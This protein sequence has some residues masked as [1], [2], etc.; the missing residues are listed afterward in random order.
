MRTFTNITEE[1]LRL[2]WE[3]DGEERELVTTPSHQFLATHGGF[4][5][6]ES[7]VSGGKGRVV[8]ADGSEAE[9]TSERI[10]YSAATADMFEQAEGYVYPENGNL[11]LKPVF[12][13]GWKTYNFEVEDFHTYVAGGVR[14]HNDSWN[15]GAGFEF[16]KEDYGTGNAYAITDLEGIVPVNGYAV[17]AYRLSQS[18]SY[19]STPQGRAESVAFG[20]AAEGASNRQVNA[21]SWSEYKAK[22]TEGLSDKAAAAWTTAH[23]S[24]KEFSRFEASIKHGRDQGRE[25][26]KQINDQNDRNS[27]RDSEGSRADTS[28]SSNPA[29]RGIGR[30]D[31][32]NDGEVSAREF[33]RAENEGQFETDNKAKNNNSDGNSGGNGGS[34]G[35]PVLLDLDGDGLD[36]TALDRST[37]FL[38]TGGD[39]FL[40]RTAW[41]DAGDG[42]LFYDPDGRDGIT[43]KRQFV[44]TEWDPTATSDLEALASVFDSNSDGVL[45]AGDAEFGK[46]KV[47]V[48]LADGSTVA[49][50]L[51][52]L[53]ITAID[54][55]ADAT[56]IELADGSVITGKTTF[57]RSDGTTGTV[58]DML[59]ASEAQGHRVEQ[60]ENVDGTGT[61]TLVS[62]AYAADGS[63]AYEIQSATSADGSSITNRYDDDGDGVTDRIQ[64]IVTVQNADNSET[65]TEETL[66]G[67]DAAT[68]VL[69]SRTVTTV[70]A[71]GLTETIERDTMGGGW[72]NQREV[73]TEQADGSLT[74]VIS[75]LAENGTMIKSRSETV[76]S[77]GSVRVDGIDADGD[78]HADT[79]ETHGIAVHA[80]DSRTE[81]VAVTNQD[82]SLRS[83][84]T[85]EVG[86]DGRSKVITRDLDGNGQTDQQEILDITVAPSG[87][88]T[89]RLDIRN[90]DGSLKSSSV[91]VTSDD[92]L[93]KT[94]ELDQDG[95]GDIDLKTVDTTTVNA[96]GSREQVIT[97]WNGDGSVRAMRKETLGSDKVSF[98]TFVDLNQ[99]GSFDAGERVSFVSVDDTT[100]ARTAT[101]WTRN[102]DGSASA[103][104]TSVTSADGLSSS[105]ESDL[106]GDGDIDLQV[107][108]VTVL[109][110]DG[111]SKRTVTTK[112]QDNS[113]RT[114]VE[115]ETSVDGLTRTVREDVDGKSDGAFEKISVT[116]L[117]LEADGGSKQTAT[118]YAGDGTTVLSKTVTTESADRRI[119]TVRQDRDGDGA[120]DVVSERVE[121]ED[122]SRTLTETTYAN[123]GTVLGQSVSTTSANGL[124]TTTQTDLDGDGNAD[125]V[126][127]ST[128][129]LNADGSQTTVQ[130]T[131]NGDG[132][133]RS[134]STVT[135]SDDGL[136]T[137]TRT[138]ADG[139]GTFERVIHDETVLDADGGTTRTVETRSQSGA[140]INR[141]Q[142]EVSDDGLVREIRTDRDGNGSYDL[143]ETSSTVLEADGDT[144]TTTE[145]RE[146][147]VLRSSTTQTV[148]DN[149]RSNVAETDVN[150]DGKTDT[151]ITQSVADSGLATD[152]VQHK[153]ADGSVQ[154]QVRTVTSANGLSATS[155]QDAD[156]NGAYETRTETVRTLNVDGS[157]TTTTSVKAQ[158]GALQ[159]KSQ[160]TVSDNGLT[161]TRTQDFDGDDNVDET[162]VRETAIASDGS[163]TTTETVTARNNDT[164][165]RS[166]ETTSGDGRSV[167][168]SVDA[169][170]DG[171]NDRVTT[172]TLADDGVTTTVAEAFS[173]SGDP[174][175]RTTT[176]ASGNGLERT[177]SFD[178]DGN[179]VAER[180]MQDTTEIASDGTTTRRV[181]H[182][183]G[184]GRLIAREEMTSSDDGLIV[185]TAL[186]LDGQGGNDFVTTKT[187]SFGHDGSSE[188]SW[189]TRGPGGQKGSAVVTTSANGLE[190]DTLIDMDGDGSIDRETAL[191]LGATGGSTETMDFN[192]VRSTV[193]SVSANGRSQTTTIDRKDGQGTDL[194]IQTSVDLSGDKTTTWTD[195]TDGGA[196]EAVIRREA[197]ANG[198]SDLY[199][200]DI[201]GNG[202]DDITRKTVVDY[203]A[204]GNEIR[205]FE[206]LEGSAGVLAFKSTTITSA[207]GLTSTTQTDSD[208]DGE[209]DT[210][211]E[212][213]T[214]FN[215]DGSSTTTSRDWHD[216]GTL[217]S[218]YAETVSADGRTIVESFDFD[219]NS[220]TDKTVV[221]EVAADGSR[222]VT[223]T[224]FGA[225]GVQKRIVTKT[226]SDGLTTTVLRDG[227]SEVLS[228]SAVGNGSYDWDNGVRA[229]SSKAH[230]F[231]THKI[232]GQGLETWEMTSTQ[233]GVATTHSERFDM[234][235][236]DRLLAEAA[237]LYDAVLDRAMDNS[238]IEVLV[239]YASNSQLNLTALANA[240]LSSGEYA[241]RYGSLSDTGFI[242]R[243]YQ[244]TFGREPTLAELGEH[245]AELTSGTSRAAL[246]AGLSESAE[247][248]VVGN[249]HGKTNNYD[250]F[251]LP[252]VKE[253]DLIVSFG[254]E[255]FDLNTSDD[256]AL[257]GTNASQTLNIGSH[258]AV[259]GLGGNDS[260]NGGNGS[261]I[262]VGGTGNDGL[263]GGAG[264]DVYIVNRG[265]GDDVI[266]DTGSGANGDRL[267]FGEGIDIEDL[268]MIRSGDHLRIE[269][270]AESAAEAAAAA[271]KGLAPLTGS[272]TIR[273][274]FSDNNLRVERLAFDNGESY[275]IGHIS[276]F[277]SEPGVNYNMWRRRSDS[278]DT[279]TA[280]PGHDIILGAGGNDTL[281]GADGNDVLLG[282]DGDDRL[283]GG[284]GNDILDAGE[285]SGSSWQY[286]YGQ[287]GD[288]TYIFGAKNGKVYIDHTETSNTGT[289]T[290][291][292]DE[293]TLNDFSFSTYDF[294]HGGTVQTP[295][296]IGLQFN[297]SGQN[298][299]ALR[300][301][302]MGDHIERYEFADGTVLSRVAF[303]SHD[304]MHFE[305]TDGDD[306]IVG[307]DK[308][309]QIYGGHGDDIIDVGGAA[310]FWQHARGQSGDDTYLIGSNAGRV[311][312][313][314]SSESS[315]NDTIRFKDLTLAD[316]NVI[317]EA[318]EGQGQIL[319]LLW[320][321]NG[322][323]GEL[324]LADEGDHI[325]RFEFA[326]GVT[327]SKIAL[328]SHDRIHVEGTGGDDLIIGTDKDDQI[329]G[330]HGNDIIDVGGAA[331]FWQHARGQSGDDTYLIGSNAG[332]VWIMRSSESS[333]NDTVRFKDLTLADLNVIV[334]AYEG[335]GQILRLLWN[336]N[337]QSGE[338]RL[339]DEGD[340]IERFE[341]AD[342]MTLSKIA[343]SSHD[344]LHL[345]GT[346][347]DDLIIGSDK[348]DQIYGG[349]GDDTI[350]VGGA[351]SF[352]QHAR[353][354]S[355]DDTY[356]IGSDAG[357]IWI[358][359]SSESSGN[360]TVRFKDLTL[361][362]LN[363]IVEAYEGQGQ[364]LRLLWN[365]NGQSGE[366]RLADEGD[367]IERFE[368]ADGAT[369]SKIALSSH[370]R[371]HLEGTNGDDLIIGSDKDDQIYG[372]AGN[373]TI[374]V[375]AGAGHWQHARGQSGD[376]TYLIG[377]EAGNV[378]IMRSS[379]SSGYD[380]VRFKDLALADLNV[381]VEAYEGQG[382]ILRLLWNKD[383]KSGQ[384]RL[385]DEGDHIERFE[386]ADGT[387]LA[388]V[389]LRSDGRLGLTGDSAANL[390][391]GTD[392]DEYLQGRAGD[393]ILNGGA[394]SDVIR[395]GFG[396]DT[397]FGGA[398]DDTIYFENGDNFWTN[399]IAR[400]V[401]GEGRDKLI[402]EAGSSFSTDGLSWYGFEEFVGAELSDR[403]IG[404]DGNIDYRLDGGAGN[405]VL[406]GSGGND[407]IRGGAG[408]DDVFGGAGNDTIYFDTGDLFWTDGIARNIGGYGFDTLIVEAG[409]SFSTGGLTWYGFEA[410]VG[411]ELNDSVTGNSASVD[412]VLNGGGGDDVLKGNGG[413]DTLIGGLG[414]DVLTGNG[415]IDTF[416]FSAE[417]SNDH[418]T[419][420]TNGEDLIQIENGAT[421]FADLSISAS[422]SDALIQFGGTTITL[423]GVSVLDLDQ[424]D[425]LFS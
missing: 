237:R 65:E 33:R 142:T 44:F 314:R 176:T 423:D 425:F 32:D 212:T 95:D 264:D 234:A 217:R 227:V 230:I 242:A 81:T 225:N 273:Y 409:S 280:D 85:E 73:R 324:R 272:V 347:G 184:S 10:V 351:A 187:I 118:A 411:A 252:I 284:N 416:I 363:V 186:D 149:G 138:D 59:L 356:L 316:L 375:G 102:A 243:A 354:Q 365:K 364:I 9:V 20:A 386:F 201:D 105:T 94:T 367:H 388:S 317:V 112:N 192:G 389:K 160:K 131:E 246:I 34:G 155:Y 48:T 54:L 313:M 241:A 101:S 88:S 148:S 285:G 250:V 219:G 96:D 84:V 422:G 286:L 196:T 344:R 216:D 325:E 281:Y 283:Y 319:R 15:D 40:R 162:S 307:T 145:T 146:G 253:D 297:L 366:L 62:T 361:A 412:Y 293:L 18:S 14:V 222:E 229:S 132:T 31:Y 170:G 270:H 21:A 120:D 7:L 177:A 342:G 384:L 87:G 110:G 268:N 224:G 17:A 309:D 387:T 311:W 218:S 328:S 295:A 419:D 129:V 232:D 262:L 258:E 61:R 315:G 395:G 392:L 157:T 194:R 178:L 71:D 76:S 181:D 353:G 69:K 16:H 67:S 141:T 304:R 43:E 99:N 349:H 294:T 119:M 417:S 277:S 360:D 289:D 358:M 202:S 338:L 288:D 70:S 374:D 55:T 282:G 370:D 410:F 368:F 303:S 343:L 111:S 402:V 4:R 274:W 269:F 154:S 197:A 348:D 68:A 166:V 263:R 406:T 214:V 420:F 255:G 240:L 175:S 82:G 362:D 379:D 128:T 27:G 251:L 49:K 114:K 378:W 357:R 134:S 36:V 287:Q 312:I 193:T 72:F 185:T 291:V 79:V 6:I 302:N 86:S 98:E 396:K 183:T 97:Q 359:R 106:D 326:D 400:D 203:D 109:N 163:I 308:D 323:S 408:D 115:T 60:V 403:V 404:N 42:V 340:H 306:L 385:A 208:G 1:W 391:N 50:T 5:E 151:R 249:G 320:N 399:G 103:K 205:V 235:A 139:N 167:T 107:E 100:L 156:G 199:R 153:A 226:S 135:V 206:E 8:L 381:I 260:L 89:S 19:D 24:A 74:I 211:A 104:V 334:E 221:S 143:I 355:G 372:G 278:N 92:A 130:Q 301:A 397:V 172:T 424:G 3:E 66:A 159:S 169:D 137:V 188:E 373:D 108:D 331:S 298:S 12:K 231:V 2:T 51:A 57:T 267:V 398:G 383:G 341:F 47:L 310:S 345:E 290:I 213:K 327:V 116:T 257:V 28:R 414:D 38:D 421:A 332:R 52:E 405:D 133:L 335:Q 228:R 190:T 266:I 56:N 77:D 279:F 179:G 321:K 191:V 125:V 37:I 164:L 26:A 91:T 144:V 238:E 39:G 25:V 121:A 413:K 407:V 254:V 322:Q 171:I 122:G 123:D 22:S 376:D 63:K 336:K 204:S 174:I 401:G 318:Y 382:Q 220:V 393:D 239:Q 371:L 83:K 189:V 346:D 11:A 330:G 418:I 78:G 415:G 236:K 296:G 150:G 165:M 377:S 352:W 41:A 90:G 23:W 29:D 182:E 233:N 337:G 80:D 195:L 215:A 300:I 147:G 394:G 152:H 180:V 299:G 124:E 53:G 58:G 275:W 75:D 64:T 136:K 276:S 247:H 350:D 209:I 126:S 45:D 256:S 223:E 198:T 13:K 259:F 244:N 210:T 158:N 140:V 248:I 339:A 292:F 380:T 30:G 173:G 46:F 329:Y 113:L 117:E 261:D 161:V 200:L 265:E 35:K 333:G 245:L 127:R 93:T 168:L 369:L 207:N 390:I 305:G 271:A